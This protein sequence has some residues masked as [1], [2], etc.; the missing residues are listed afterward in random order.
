MT[1]LEI[2]LLRPVRRTGISTRHT[3]TAQDKLIY[4]KVDHATLAKWCKGRRGFVQV[5][6][7]DGADWLPFDSVTIVRTPRG[8]SG[9]AVFEIDNF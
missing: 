7:H 9:E 1:D 6:A 8:Y 4:H 3:V 2:Y 5:C